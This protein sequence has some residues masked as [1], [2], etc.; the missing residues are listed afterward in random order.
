MTATR[1]KLPAFTAAAMLIALAACM[2]QPGGQYGGSEAI[3][4]LKSDD[5]PTTAEM[6]RGQCWMRF[7]NNPLAKNVDKKLELVEKCIEEKRRLYP[8]IVR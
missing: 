6:A 2:T 4:K 1:R 5:P 8:H 3:K 7:E